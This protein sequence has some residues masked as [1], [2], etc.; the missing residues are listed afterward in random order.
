MHLLWFVMSFREQYFGCLPIQTMVVLISFKLKKG[1]ASQYASFIVFL[2]FLKNNISV[3]QP[4][5]KGRMSFIQ[6]DNNR[7]SKAHL[8][9][10]HVFV[11]RKVCLV[12]VL[13]LPSSHFD[14]VHFRMFFRFCI[15]CFFKIKHDPPTTL[16]LG[17]SELF[18]SLL[19]SIPTRL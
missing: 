5:K 11:F 16:E 18:N 12:L 1:P 3:V 2:T 8:L 17:V 10:F 15:L 9:V 14:F 7:R 19:L 6:L 13:K 4:S